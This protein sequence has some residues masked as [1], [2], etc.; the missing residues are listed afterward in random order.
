MVSVQI[1]QHRQNSRMRIH[2]ELPGFGLQFP[3]IDRFN[4]SFT[5][6]LL[7]ISKMR[8]NFSKD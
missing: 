5:Y 3:Q 1:L 2:E 4:V 8:S 7:H 6:N